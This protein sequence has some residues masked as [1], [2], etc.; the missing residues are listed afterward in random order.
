MREKLIK[1]SLLD[2][3][4]IEQATQGDIF[5]IRY[6]LDFFSSYTNKLATRKLYDE[7]GICQHVVD[8][9][10]KSRIESRL[11]SKIFEFNLEY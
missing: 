11:V 5:A 10:L 7:F 4:V 3:E 2:Y 1:Q 9:E 6:V 8:H